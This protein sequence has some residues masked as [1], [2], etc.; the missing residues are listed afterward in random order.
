MLII[1]SK[2]LL[3]EGGQAPPHHRQTPYLAEEAVA[4][5]AAAGVDAAINHPPGWDA[6]SNRYAIEAAQHFPERFATLGW[7]KLD[8][9]EAP[10]LVRRWRSQPGM[11]GFRFLC[12]APDERSWP[13][14]GTM[15]WLWPLSQGFGLPN[16]VWGAKPRAPLG[17]RG[18]QKP[19]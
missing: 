2:F 16:A 8:R 14:D 15:E 18:A 5:M 13:T 3:W 9:P 11:I 12:V 1:D 10:D 19:D 4:D 6:D 17:G 7:L